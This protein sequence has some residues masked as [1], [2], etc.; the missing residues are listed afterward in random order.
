MCNARRRRKMKL[1]S[2][3]PYVRC[4]SNSGDRLVT[5]YRSFEKFELPAPRRRDDADIQPYRIFNVVV[6][7]NEGSLDPSP[8]ATASPVSRSL[9]PPRDQDTGCGPRTISTQITTHYAALTPLLFFP[10]L[11]FRPIWK[12]YIQAYN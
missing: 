12:K 1:K 7:A 8:W 5:C 11:V 9:S 10:C 2:R 4:G 3:I 6:E